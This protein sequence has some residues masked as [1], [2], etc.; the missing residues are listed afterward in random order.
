L[1]E[2][3]AWEATSLPITTRELSMNSHDDARETSDSEEE[4]DTGLTG[5]GGPA[6]VIYGDGD[7]EEADEIAEDM[8][9][10]PDDESGHST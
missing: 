1:R 7:K 10:A 8:L 9:K 3:A 5:G 4:T 6:S 2:L